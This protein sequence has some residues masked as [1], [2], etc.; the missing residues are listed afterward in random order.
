MIDQELIS[1]ANWTFLAAY[2]SLRIPTVIVQCKSDLEQI[3]PAEHVASRA[4]GYSIG[5]VVAST[6]TEIGKKKAKDSFGWL[7]KS[8]WRKRRTSK[9]VVGM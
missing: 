3:V 7:M 8:I 6:R 2:Y 4:S 1:S 5:L 9:V